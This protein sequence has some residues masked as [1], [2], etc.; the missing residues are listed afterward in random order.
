[1]VGDAQVLESMC[2]TGGCDRVLD[3]SSNCFPQSSITLP[4]LQCVAMGILSEMNLWISI[5]CR[6]QTYVA[7]DVVV[8]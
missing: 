7:G 4:F 1:M 6:R 2:V 3:P 8:P 5:Y